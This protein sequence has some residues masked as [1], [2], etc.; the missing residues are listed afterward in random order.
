MR[1]RVEWALVALALGMLAW[2]FVNLELSSFVWDEPRF[3]MLAEEQLRTGRFATHTWEGTQGVAYGPLA[4]WF[5]AVVHKLFG[6][7]PVVSVGA[8]CAALSLMHLGFAAGLARLFGGGRLMFAALVAWIASS[9]YLFFWS[10]TAWD[11]LHN[12][13]VGIAV[14]ILAA[15]RP[16][17]WKKGLLLGVVLGLMATNHLMTLPFIALALAVLALELR[18]QP[19]RA[20]AALGAAL[21]AMLIVNL[22]Y[23]SY[24]RQANPGQA[25]PTSFSASSWIAFVW[26]PLRVATTAGIDYFFDAAWSDF[27]AWLGGWSSPALPLLVAALASAG[28]IIAALRSRDP[29]QRRIA[30]LAL[31]AWIVYPLFYATRGLGIE[32]PHYNH[33]TWWIV[34]F[35]IAGSLAWLGKTRWEPVAAAL[36]LA[37]AAYQL[38][39]QISWMRYIAERGG[40][41]GVHYSAPLREQIR[42]VAAACAFPSRDIFLENHTVLFPDALHYTAYATPACAGKRVQVCRPGRC[43]VDGATKVVRLRYAGAGGALSV[44]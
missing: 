4:L 23:L 33:P 34:P 36:V 10:R 1:A 32:H 26:G 28:G 37:V 21:A 22:P 24:L 18:R 40:T 29:A 35:G 19:K 3:M 11:P 14:V 12:G 38:A 25:A 27:R 43:P 44:E 42:A 39:F 41:Q 6:P 16:Q 9:P 31:G 7:A 30:L 17:G 20:A 13:L 2:R 15:P 8:L 5:Y